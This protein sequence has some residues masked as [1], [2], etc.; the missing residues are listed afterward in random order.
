MGYRD[1]P[2][3]DSG[4]DSLTA[5]SFRNMLQSSLSL[6]VPASLIF[7]YPTLQDITSHL[8]E[9]SVAQGGEEED[10]EYEEIE[11]VIEDDS[12]PTLAVVP[13]A[14]VEIE[15]VKKGLDADLVLN[16]VQTLAREAIGVDEML[17]VD[18]P[19]MDSGMDSLTSV[20]FRNQLQST[21]GLK[22]PSSLIF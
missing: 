13:A 19:L 17:Y 3:M 9:I 4:M 18:S 12:F 20:S 14:P 10:D 7:D 22:V 1:S 15:P 8:L 16:T 11:E 2:L 21:L 6:K 5:V